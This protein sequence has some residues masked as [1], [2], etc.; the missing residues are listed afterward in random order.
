[1]YDI[2]LEMLAIYNLKI[3]NLEFKQKYFNPLIMTNMIWAKALFLIDSRS[4]G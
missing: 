1:M 4:V 2:S 3:D